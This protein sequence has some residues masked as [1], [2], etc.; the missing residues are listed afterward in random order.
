[1]E[2]APANGCVTRPCTTDG[3]CDCGYCVN[4]ACRP[5]LGFCYEMLAMPYGC[6]WPDEELV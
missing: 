3:E 1:V 5:T 4:S 2:S 6:V